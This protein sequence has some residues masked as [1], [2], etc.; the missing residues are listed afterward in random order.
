MRLL[1]KEQEGGGCLFFSLP[2]FHFYFF[3]FFCSV[4][5]SIF[6]PV[7][8]GESLVFFL[9][10]KS[11]YIVWWNSCEQIQ[12]CRRKRSLKYGEQRIKGCEGRSPCHEHVQ[13]STLWRGRWLLQLLLRLLQCAHNCNQ[14]NKL[15]FFISIIYFFFFFFFLNFIFIFFIIIYVAPS[16]FLPLSCS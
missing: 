13:W 15:H 2:H 4:Y 10:P 12:R 1:S 6:P 3:F 7:V 14:K 8:E 11:Q 5:P 9:V 16:L